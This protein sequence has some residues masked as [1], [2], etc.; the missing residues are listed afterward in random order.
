MTFERYDVRIEDV[1]GILFLSRQSKSTSQNLYDESKHTRNLKI[2][3]SWLTCTSKKKYSYQSHESTS[4]LTPHQGSKE[5]LPIALVYFSN[6][7]KVMPSEHAKVVQVSKV[8][9]RRKLIRI[10]HHSKCTTN[11]NNSSCCNDS[12]NRR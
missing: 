7:T 5:C 3:K 4:H 6:R 9:P 12:T 8:G 11:T 1:K 2:G 10:R